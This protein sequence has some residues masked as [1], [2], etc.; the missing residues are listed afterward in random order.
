[1]SG[2]LARA[3]LSSEAVK[4]V[5]LHGTGTP[6]GDPIEVGALSAALQ[7]HSSA[8]TEQVVAFGSNKVYCC[9]SLCNQA[10]VRMDVSYAS[11][12]QVT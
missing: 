8:Q 9:L 3:A 11:C 1:M 7:P 12:I 6:L 2:C 4:Y 10:F 5:A